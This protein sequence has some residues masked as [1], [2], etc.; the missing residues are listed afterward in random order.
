MSVYKLT[1]SETGKIYYGST[2]Q[3]LENRKQ[4][5]WQRCSCEDFVNPTI[6][7]VETVNDLDNLLE[8]ED[9]YIRNFECINKYR[10][11]ITDEEKKEYFRQYRKDNREKVM[12]RMKAYREKNRDRI[13]AK[14]RELYNKNKDM[15][16]AKD[17]QYRDNNREKIRARKRELYH[18]NRE[19]IRARK[20]AYRKKNRDKINARQRE[21]R[22]LKKLKEQENV[23]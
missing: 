2:K 13:N 7:L 3:T 11:M 17:K 16:L 5:G 4:K 18:K 6:E 8:R 12:A 1:C 20:N 10:V 9:Y 15:I 23:K 22:R 19:K 14:R 21:R